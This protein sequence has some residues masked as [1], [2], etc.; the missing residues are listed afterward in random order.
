[1]IPYLASICHVFLQPEPLKMNCWYYP[2]DYPF[3]VTSQSPYID[4]Y[5]GEPYYYLVNINDKRSI[6]KVLMKILSQPPV[7]YNY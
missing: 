1:M 4:D 2:D 7:R 3:Q 6:H 5:I